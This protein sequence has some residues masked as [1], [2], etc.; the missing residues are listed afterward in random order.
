[1]K[2]I[3]GRLVGDGP[4]ALAVRAKIEQ[5]LGGEMRDDLPDERAGQMSARNASRSVSRLA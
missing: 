5:Y 4:A 3:F 2:A 1:M